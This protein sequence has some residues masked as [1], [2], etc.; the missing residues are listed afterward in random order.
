MS[1]NVIRL[2]R[3]LSNVHGSGESAESVGLLNQRDAEILRLQSQIEQLGMELQQAREQSYNMGFQDGLA[4]EAQRHRQELETHAAEFRELGENLE[5]EFTGI[6]TKQEQSL[7]SMSFHIAEKILT[8]ALP[9]E[10]RNE[11]LVNTVQ[12]FLKDV[13]HAD[14]VVIHVSPEQLHLVQSEEVTQELA[15]SFPGRIQFVADRSLVPGECMVETP[16]HLIDGRYEAQLATLEEQ[17]R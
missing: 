9:D 4:A 12:S 6:L 2:H 10:V 7:T 8:R 14:H 16:E 3:P 15:E 1:L 5:Q 11:A 13:L 17:L